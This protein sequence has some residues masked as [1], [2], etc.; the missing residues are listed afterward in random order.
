MRKL[1]NGLTTIALGLMVLGGG[2]LAARLAVAQESAW[3]PKTLPG[4]ATAK[5]IGSALKSGMAKVGDVLIPSP[6]VK[7][8]PDPISLSIKADPSPELYL[9][10]ATVAEESGNVAGARKHYQQA[11]KLAPER[12]DVIL[13]YARFRDRRGE[14]AEATELY[15]RAVRSNADEPSVFND[16]GLCFARRNMLSQSLSALE[17]AIQLA[18]DRRLYRNNIATILVEQGNVDAA[19]GHLKAVHDEAVAY[20]NLGYLMLKKGESRAAARLFSEALAKNPSLVEARIWLR[21]LE[22]NGAKPQNA[23]RQAP[24][25]RSATRQPPQPA[26]RPRLSMRPSPDETSVQGRQL[27]L[28]PPQ[29]RT[30]APPPA[31]GSGWNP[32]HMAPMPPSTGVRDGRWPSTAGTRLSVPVRT[33]MPGSGAD[34]PVPVLQPLPP[35]D[36]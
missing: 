27:Q 32:A 22:S 28:L 19:F 30:I 2:Q 21:K 10:M 35:V 4:V 24:Q 11:L 3:K 8:A 9:S 5:S 16:L 26:G 36:K 6:F 12:F 34:E 13:P 7:E 1:S 15:Q 17:R 23:R 18:P 29:P 20:Y 31:V 14:L 25:L 33:P